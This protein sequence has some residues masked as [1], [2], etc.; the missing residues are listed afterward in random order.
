[1]RNQDREQKS[2]G[3]GRS[4]KRKGMILLLFFLI[5]IFL[6]LTSIANR[7]RGELQVERLDI[8]GNRILTEKEV[9]AL[10]KVPVG[11]SLY[12]VD[13]LEVRSRLR[14]NPYVAEAVVAHDLPATI[15]V[16]IEERS[17]IAIL[18]GPELFYVNPEGYVLPPVTS[19]EIFD[20]PIITGLSEPQ[21][22]KAGMRI[23]SGNFRAAVEILTQAADLDRMDSSDKE[24]SHLISEINIGSVDLTVYTVEH[25][26]P[27]LFRKENI[28]TQLLYLH[29]FWDQYMRQQGAEQV[30]SID[31][32]FEEQVVVSWNKPTLQEKSL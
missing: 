2:H 1:M 15:K 16:T 29:K 17:P 18:G 9:I 4:P 14:T 8:R 27:I 20:L 24:L 10:A 21:P 32:R 23:V 30:R 13:L 19:K 25:G 31:L 28:G 22:I 5:A 12:E 7:W 26:I 3:G 11:A 6:G